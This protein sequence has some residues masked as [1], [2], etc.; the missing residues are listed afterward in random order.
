MVR[1]FL[2]FG[3]LSAGLAVVSGAF[4]AHALSDRITPARLNTFEIAVRYQMYHALAL[5]ATAW[6]FS[7]WWKKILWMH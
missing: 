1:F 5:F 6:V 2:F 7:M 4:G 3:A